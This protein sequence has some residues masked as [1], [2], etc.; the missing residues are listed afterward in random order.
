M[1]RPQVLFSFREHVRFFDVRMSEHYINNNTVQQVGVKYYVCN[2][3]A[4]KMHNIKYS[5]AFDQLCTLSLYYILC[6]VCK[7]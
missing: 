7:R 6:C 1:F 3:A 4:R 2:I 5:V